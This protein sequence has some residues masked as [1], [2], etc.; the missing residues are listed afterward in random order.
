MR[1]RL[2]MG[3]AAIA[4]LVVLLLGVRAVW[5]QRSDRAGSNAAIARALGELETG[6]PSAA[7]AAARAA[8]LADS[9]YGLA[10]AVLARAQ[11][12]LD[13]GAGAAASLDRAGKAGFDL[14]RVGQL[15]AH[16]TYL[17]GDAARA[18]AEVERSDP[19]YA[20]Y[21]D[22]VRAM[23]LA[24]QGEGDRARA[25]LETAVATRPGDWPS[26]VTL[27][28][29][30]L[31][32]G[33]AGGAIIA[34]ARAHA[35]DPRQVDSLRL[36]AEMVRSQFG[37]MAALPWFERAVAR[38]PAHFEALIE[39]AATLGDVGRMRAMLAAVRRAEAVRPAAPRALYL[40]AVLAA[41]AGRFDLAE[42]IV[43]RLGGAG[44]GMPGVLLL[45]GSI[46]LQ[47]GRLEQ[48][49][50]ALQALVD[51]QP[52]NR[53]ARRL[54]ALALARS[55]GARGATDVLR[56]VV[57]RGD[58][59]SYALALAARALERM[60]ER[61]PASALL[62][63]AA[64]PARGEAVAFAGGGDLPA[65][66]AAARAAGGAPGATIAFVRALVLRGEAARA[67]AEAQALAARY[68]GL[69]AAHAAIGDV[70]MLTG[71]PVPAAQAFAR[72]ASIGFDEPILLRLVEARAAAGQQVGAANALALFVSQ[73]PGNLAALRLTGAWQL[74]G[75]EYGGAVDTL[76]AIRARIGNRDAGVM[77][78]LAAAYVGVGEGGRAL[79]YARAAY[80]LQPQ[81]PVVADAYGQ[82][83]AATGDRAGAVQLFRKAATIAPR[84]PAIRAHLAET[85]AGY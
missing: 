3:G 46:N 41:R 57:Q 75:G 12:A 54:L 29:L 64:T 22:R 67:L 6:N 26:W 85:L 69:P 45:K 35:A 61:E 11:L 82:A 23:A 73:H 5:P 20:R 60:G 18:L 79:E 16:A 17:Q 9:G 21:A 58:A 72:A 84:H 71:Q 39:Y 83:L 55:D 74:A 44:E 78:G 51:R 76:E 50:E 47:T 77:A 14:R 49:I 43:Q 81:N 34:S 19:R 8:V 2:V 13:D 70:L 4:L 33:D 7:V 31:E 62:D 80:A 56:P 24:D 66:L 30:R 65:L 36:R 48:A 42:A 53:S 59:D 27:G 52:R 1:R 63:R 10:H 15:R 68:P 40:Q 32:N 25:L 37:P 38:D 28:R